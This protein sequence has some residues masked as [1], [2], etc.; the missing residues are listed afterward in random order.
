MFVF[1]LVGL[2]VPEEGLP[3]ILLPAKSE[4]VRLIGDGT[5][6]VLLP[7]SEKKSRLLPPGPTSR[8]RRSPWSWVLNPF[9]VTVTPFTVP[10][11]LV[12][13]IFEGYGAAAP[14]LAPRPGAVIAPVLQYAYGP[15]PDPEVGFVVAVSTRWSKV[16]LLIPNS[17]PVLVPL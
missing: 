2:Y 5:V 13:K 8:E 7:V 17:V 16:A 4:K 9:N 15:A 12:T 14:A 10:G 3:P 11:R 1:K 6:E